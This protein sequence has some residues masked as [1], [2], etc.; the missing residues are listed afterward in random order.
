MNTSKGKYYVSKGDAQAQDI[1]TMFDGVAILKIDGL[2]KRGKTVNV[3]HE[4]WIDSQEEDYIVG[5]VDEN[6]ND[7]IIRENQDLEITFIVSQRYATGTINVLQKHDAF[8]DYMTNGKVVVQS[9]YLG[10]RHVVATCLDEYAPTSIELNRGT[11]SYI[12]G[13]IK[14]HMLDAVSN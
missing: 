10:G 4:Q 5:N 3:Y 2:L 7:V 8:I 13:T 6:D 12:M 1:T 9:E 11:D 14:M